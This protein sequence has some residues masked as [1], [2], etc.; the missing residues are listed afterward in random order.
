MINLDIDVYI[1][2]DKDLCID[3]YINDK[4]IY[5]CFRW[6]KKPIIITHGKL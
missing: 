6:W 1:D 5:T 3:I 2:A 4:E